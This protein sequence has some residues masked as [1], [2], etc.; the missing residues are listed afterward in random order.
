MFVVIPDPSLSNSTLMSAKSAISTAKAIRVNNAAKNAINDDIM[1]ITAE[2]ENIA[3]TNA[4][5][6]AMVA[7]HEINKNASDKKE[8]HCMILKKLTDRMN[9][10][11][12]SPRRRN[13]SG[14]GFLC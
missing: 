14:I 11:S 3:K 13:S 7:A 6:A 5:N 8:N 1:P 4:T 10:Q 9:S 2:V 12:T